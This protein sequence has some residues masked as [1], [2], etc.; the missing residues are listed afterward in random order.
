VSRADREDDASAEGSEGA[1]RRTFFRVLTHLPVKS[2]AV[3]AREVEA[4]TRELPER[5]APDFSRIDPGLAGWLDRIERKL[6]RVLLHL[7][8]GDPVA[9]G[10]DDVQEVMLS[11]AG[12]SLASDA[13]VPPGELTL[14]EF[15]IPGTPAHLVR[16][17]ARVIRHHRPK[18]AGDP[19]TSAVAFEV[20]NEA[21]REA[22]VRHAVEVQRTLIRTRGRAGAEV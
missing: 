12:M 18:K 2:R 9:F 15:E 7:G 21:D 19:V 4:L 16:C 3:S 1:E 14:V 11:G 13:P 10:E 5:R 20:I 22:I 17:L 8:I 6:D